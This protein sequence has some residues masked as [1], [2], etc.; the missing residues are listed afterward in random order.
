M[1]QFPI[2]FN[3]SNL[4]FQDTKFLQSEIWFVNMLTIDI[5]VKKSFSAITNELNINWWD[6]EVFNKDHIIDEHF[7]CYKINTITNKPIIQSQWM[8]TIDLTS[9]ESIS[10]KLIKTFLQWLPLVSL[11]ILSIITAILPAKIA[12]VFRY[13]SIIG[14]LITC[15]FYAFKVLKMFYK[16]LT[17]K[18]IDYDGINVYY[19]FKEDMS[20]ICTEDIIN[21]KNFYSEFGIQKLVFIHWLCYIKQTIT[22]TSYR[23]RAKSIF[24]W[25]SHKKKETKELIERTIQFFFNISG[26]IK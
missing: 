23:E 17:S 7:I 24:T 18:A 13:I 2:M 9:R 20:I 1:D 14:I 6:I 21:L 25:A 19:Q 8:I 26:F 11:F 3:E 4:Y 5:H 22:E 16:T 12:F 10:K 15:V